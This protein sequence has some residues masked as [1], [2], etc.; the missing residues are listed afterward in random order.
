MAPVNIWTNV[1]A[2]IDGERRHRDL[3]CKGLA[4]LA[5]VDESTVRRML[6]GEP[7][8]LG[9]LRAVAASLE[10]GWAD[11]L[12]LVAEPVPAVQV[13]GSHR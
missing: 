12:S 10:L 3:T 8:R 5:A 9:S 13:S 1:A 7:T 6:V 11:L 2:V 4:D